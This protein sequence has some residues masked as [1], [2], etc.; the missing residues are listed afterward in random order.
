V[1]GTASG[2]AAAYLERFG[3]IDTDA[4]TFEQGEFVDRG[5]RVHVEVPAAPTVDGVRVGGRAVT[6]LDGTLLVPE[7]DEEEILEV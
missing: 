2:A 4:M 7:H 5:G 6:A 3:A 1:T